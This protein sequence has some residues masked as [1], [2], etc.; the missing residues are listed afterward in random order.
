MCCPICEASVVR[1]AV[2]AGLTVTPPILA[3]LFVKATSSPRDANVGG[4]FYLAL[5]VAL[6][7]AA[8]VVY[9]RRSSR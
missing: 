4:A 8:A 1:A 9:L 3:V 5:G 6:G 7:I 2:A